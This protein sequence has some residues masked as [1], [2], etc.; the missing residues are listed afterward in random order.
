MNYFRIISKELITKAMEANETLKDQRAQEKTTE[1]R[2]MIP[3]DKE[4][5]EK[6]KRT[7]INIVLCHRE[8]ISGGRSGH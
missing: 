7:K 2:P 6:E 8:V 1:L 3:R 5:P 4:E